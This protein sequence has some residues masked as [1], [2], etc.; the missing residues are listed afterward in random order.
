MNR[1]TSESVCICGDKHEHAI[2]R[3]LDM[4]FAPPLTSFYGRFSKL[5]IHRTVQRM[6]TLACQRETAK[7][8]A[9][10]SVS[11]TR[12]MRSS[13]DIEKTA[14]KTTATLVVTSAPYAAA[15]DHG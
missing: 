6:V 5:N 13:E 8:N 2:E 4:P 7:S 9:V 12:W 11:T 14:A 15:C 3:L 10:T 1:I